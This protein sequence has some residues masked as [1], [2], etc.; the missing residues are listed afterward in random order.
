MASGMGLCER[1]DL[2]LGRTKCRME[3]VNREAYKGSGCRNLAASRSMAGI[4]GYMADATL[5]RS[6][7]K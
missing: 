7:D 5:W 2:R 1:G 6:L 3:V 4:R